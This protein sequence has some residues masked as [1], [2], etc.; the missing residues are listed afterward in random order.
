MDV[1]FENTYCI[2]VGLRNKAC[3]GFKGTKKEGATK[4]ER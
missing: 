2:S 1:Q 3:P 4:R